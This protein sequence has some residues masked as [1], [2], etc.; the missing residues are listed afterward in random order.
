M[1]KRISNISPISFFILLAVALLVSAGIYLTFIK[2]TE[3]KFKIQTPGNIITPKITQVP[4][5]KNQE[6][7]DKLLSNEWYWVETVVGSSVG[8]K[9]YNLS[10]FR[11]KFNEDLTF[12]SSSDC[13]NMG[14]QFEVFENKIKFKEIVKTEMYCMKSRET[15]YVEGLSNAQEFMF[16]GNNELILKF[17]DSNSYMRF[18]K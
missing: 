6:Y 13:N 1:M 10:A 9:P 11:I 7:L 17:Q 4:D 18:K 3:P 16:D 12:N 8:I 5:L 14:G 2:Y 15:E